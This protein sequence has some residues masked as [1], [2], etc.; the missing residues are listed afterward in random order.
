M[1]LDNNLVLSAAQIVT[2][3][4]DSQNIVDT[5]NAGN[6]QSPSA[7]IRASMKVAATDS[8]SDATVT[9]AIST[10]ADLVT[11]VVLSQTAAIAFAALSPAGSVLLDS[12]IPNG[13][14]RY[15]KLVY[16]VASG[17]LTAGSIDAEILL[18]T[19]ALLDR[20]L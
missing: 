8:G 3:T 14:R 1:I 13:S 5:L 4:A 10:S 6:T 19:E 18:N 17:P 12:A 16:T 9:V 2:A 11:W 15:I 20:G 7:R